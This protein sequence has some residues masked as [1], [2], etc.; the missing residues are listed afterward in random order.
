MD[1][2]D[3]VAFV[4]LSGLGVGDGLRGGDIGRR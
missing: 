3:G 2:R 1:A 4:T